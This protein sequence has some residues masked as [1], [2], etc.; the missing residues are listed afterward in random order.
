MV[1]NH[2][3]AD[4]LGGLKAFHALGIPSYASKKTL[5]LAEKDG[6]ELPQIGYSKKKTLKL[7]DEKVKL[8]YPGEAHTRDNSVAW[9]PAEKI[10]FGGCMVKAVGAGKGNVA[11][12]NEA[13]WPETVAKVRKKFN[14][15]KWVIPGHGQAGGL[16]LLDFT[17]QLFGGRP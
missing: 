17:V 2:F 14:H 16:E 3:H 12:A 4:C 9:M 8:F 7:A 6:V 13:A 5:A 15:A 11:D 10:L 1:V